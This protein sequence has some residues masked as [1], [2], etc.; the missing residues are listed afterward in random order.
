MPGRAITKFQARN[1][2]QGEKN[3]DGSIIK[4]K[5][6]ERYKYILSA[7]KEG[8]EPSTIAKVFNSTPQ[9]IQGIIKAEDLTSASQDSIIERVTRVRD[10]TLD[11]LEKAI[12]EEGA[13]V[14]DLG[15]TFAVLSDKGVMFAGQPSTVIKH[16][17]QH[18][19]HQALTDL[20]NQLPKKS[21]VIDTEIVEDKS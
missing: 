17:H 16:E 5:E 8:L 12:Q 9:T 10:L 15:I 7:I 3:R 4:K 13:K 21:E 6:P 14:K 2:K 1:P 18:L 20:A 11:K 19:T